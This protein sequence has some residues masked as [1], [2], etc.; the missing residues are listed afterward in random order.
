MFPALITIDYRQLKNK[1]L[2]GFSPGS[3]L[4]MNI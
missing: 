4:F 1:K 2:P 3:F